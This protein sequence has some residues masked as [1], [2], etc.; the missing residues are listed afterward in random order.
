MGTGPDAVSYAVEARQRLADEFGNLALFRRSRESALYHF[1]A[2]LE[3][4][5]FSAG[6]NT[7]ANF[8]AHRA[9]VLSSSR[10]IPS[11]LERCS[12]G[13]QEEPS[14]A[15]ELFLAARDLFEFSRKYE[16][17]AFSFELADRGQFEIHVARRDPRISCAKAPT[18]RAVLMTAISSAIW[19]RTNRLGVTTSTRFARRIY[20]TRVNTNVFP[21]PVGSETRAGSAR[22]VKCELI[23]WSAPICAFRRPGTVSVPIG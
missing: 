3:V 8:D 5:A 4:E 13:S 16:D 9:A 19:L 23:A 2:V 20:G 10:A 1:C 15:K 22:I 21:A 6:A 14:I 12:P 7:K 17:V 11:I 18:M